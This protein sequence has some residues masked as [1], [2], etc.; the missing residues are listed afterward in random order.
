M[1]ATVLVII[2]L[3]FIGLRRGSA[4]IYPD[5][6]NASP[7]SGDDQC[8][9]NTIPTRT[10]SVFLAPSSVIGG[11]MGMF[12][13]KPT[14]AGEIILP[15]DGP[16][17]PIIDPDW[18]QASQNAWVNLFSNYWWAHGKTDSASFE[19]HDT[20]EYQITMGALPNSHPYLIN[21][22]SGHPNVV[23]YDDSI[24][25]RNVD[26]GAG[27]ISYYMGRN[28]IAVRDVEAGEELFLEYPEENM[29]EISET[30]NIPTRIHYK[31]AGRVVS[32]LLNKHGKDWNRWSGDEKLA[33]VSERAKSLLPKSQADLEKVL[34]SARN[35]SDIALAIAKEISIEKRSVEWIKENGICLENIVPG[36]SSNQLAGKGAIANYF[37]E[38][39]DVIAP[40]SMLQITN[41]DA[42]RMPAFEGEDMQLLL[43]YCFG[44]DDSSL[45][46]C[47]NTNAIL[48]NHCSDRRPALHPCGRD[49]TPNAEYRWAA[50]DT[51]TNDWLSKTIEEMKQGG[52]RGLSLEIVATRHIEE[53]EEVF[54]DYGIKWEEA[55]DHH[56]RNWKPAPVPAE[57]AD[58]EW[59][60]AKQ[61]NE[62]LGPL[63]L[64]PD[65]SDK[66]ISNDSRGVLF[67]GCLYDENDED[68]FDDFEEGEPWRGMSVLEVVSKYGAANGD[69]Y[70]LDETYPYTDGS[71]WPCVVFQKV[72]TSEGESYTVR[73][74]QHPI[75]D[76][77]LWEKKKLP[78]IIS[79]FSR[80]SIRHFYLPYE[81]DVHLPN[82]FR[83]HMELSNAFFPQI[84][85]DRK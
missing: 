68:F 3:H 31:E 23:P 67:T 38:K 43:N 21:M 24:M 72:E 44:R 80:K 71:F 22:D 8:N 60:S 13:T 12:V 76:D 9:A 74:I 62:D 46:L 75:W 64:A 79:N 37:M 83:H 82:T 7:H 42:L 35:S 16:S 17:I 81:S 59:V 1:K 40:A 63:K 29:N 70:I 77:T 78:R 57:V 14:K 5:G 32:S 26:P 55:W 56:L 50:W 49:G 11:G 36:K 66:H 27:A 30:Y 28:T 61:R 18:S 69:A 10:C 47:P 25:D 48:L 20:T 52:G 6:E 73:I 84:W 65:L 15:A 39:G 41:R 53:G 2:L 58:E 4:V 34:R 51:A 19:A 54:I 33:S 45:L 85:R